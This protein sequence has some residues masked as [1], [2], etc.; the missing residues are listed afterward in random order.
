MGAVRKRVQYFAAHG[1][2]SLTASG[3][4]RMLETNV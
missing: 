3:F 1:K 4:G 2:N